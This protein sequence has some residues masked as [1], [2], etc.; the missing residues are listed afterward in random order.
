MARQFPND[1]RTMTLEAERLR[2][3]ELILRQKKIY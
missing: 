3:K 1:I 2:F